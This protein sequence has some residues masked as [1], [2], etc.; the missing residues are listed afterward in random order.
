MRIQACVLTSLSVAAL[1]CSALVSPVPALEWDTSSHHR[2]IEYACYGGLVPT[3][4]YDNYI[5]PVRIRG[6][7]SAVWWVDEG[8]AR[9]VMEAILTQEELRAVVARVAEAGFFGWRDSYESTEVIYDG[10]DCRLSVALASGEKT[11]WV[12][13]GAESPDGYA[14]LLTWLRTGAGAVG[15]DFVPTH[16]WLRAIPVD[17]TDAPPAL[18]WP[19]E[20][21]EGI[22]LSDAGEALP[23]SGEALATAWRIVNSDRYAQVEQAGRRYT[24]VVQI[25]DVTDLWPTSP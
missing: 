11:V 20:G 13:A 19:D 7:G 23:V 1:S 17:A 9:H 2:L 3:G 10:S 18:V 5:P 22:R 24:L 12:R 4:Y 21:I 16:G 14:D 15:H 8:S 6:D 25:E